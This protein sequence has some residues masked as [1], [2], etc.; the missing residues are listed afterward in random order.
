MDDP[1]AIMLQINEICATREKTDLA[2]NFGYKCIV[3]R[4][5][6]IHRLFEVFRVVNINIFKSLLAKSLKKKIED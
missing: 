1:N 4:D 6:Q 5:N 3:R 2:Q